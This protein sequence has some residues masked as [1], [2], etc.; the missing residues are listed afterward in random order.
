MKYLIQFS[1]LALAIIASNLAVGQT[2]KLSL[3]DAVNYG[4]KN[5]PDM[6]NKILGETYAKAQLNETRSFGIPQVSANLQFVDNIQKQVFVFPVNGTPTPIRVGNTFVSTG[7]IQA[8]WLAFDAT[9]FLGL[10]A[11]AAFT[12]LAKIQTNLTK[13]E[14]I[15]NVTKSY[16]LVLITKEN[17]G[18]L[19]QNIKTLESILFQT[20]GYYKNGFAEKIDVDRLKLALSNLN[21][22]LDALSDQV[23]ITEK[24]LK[25]N[26]GMPIDT[27]I[28]LT[29]NLESLYGLQI[30]NNDL[31]ADAKQRLEYQLLSNQ[32][33][34]AR[35]DKKQFEVGKY[36]NIVM[37]GNYQQNNFG[38]KLDYSTWYGNSFWGLKVGIPIFS[39]FNNKAQIVKRNVIIEQTLTGIKMFENAV[40]L[41]ASMALTKYQRSL[42][43]IEIQKQNLS[44]ANEILSTTNAKLKEGVGSNLEIANAQ[45][46]LK[47]SHT[48][49]LNAI[50]DLLNAQ[51]EIKKAYGKL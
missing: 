42:K 51:I 26:M 33:T 45:Q 31:K 28:E 17:I 15:I 48:N 36:P 18:L 34:L 4:V 3:N 37:F 46:E 20:E 11:A 35:L 22:Q 2:T 47:T 39:G 6:Q 29:D 50:F 27:D 38:D 8:T 16:H 25:F 13:R 19:S 14:V 30:E 10:K 44:L 9:Y 7:T 24:L 1:T 49:Y 40:N 41:E 12:E 32:L 43:A 21:T 23:Q 5:H